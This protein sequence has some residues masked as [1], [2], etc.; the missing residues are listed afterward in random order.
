MCSGFRVGDGSR[1]RVHGSGVFGVMSMVQEFRFRSEAFGLRG[2]AASMPRMSS[3]R[4]RPD[5]CTLSV[6]CAEFMFCCFRVQ[7]LAARVR[8]VAPF[9]T[10]L[11]YAIR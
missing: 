8:A 4:S 2:T 5:T 7:D 1:V 11:R 10:V 9:R 3:S 6:E